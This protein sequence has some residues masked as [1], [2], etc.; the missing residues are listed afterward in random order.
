MVKQ[1]QTT[2]ILKQGCYH[3]YH[4]HYHRDYYVDDFQYLEF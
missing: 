1:A 3:R 2:S 4:Y